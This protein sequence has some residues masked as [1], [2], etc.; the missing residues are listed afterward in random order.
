MKAIDI[1][2]DDKEEDGT[3]RSLFTNDT[4]PENIREFV[5]YKEA[6]SDV[7]ELRV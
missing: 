6:N 7:E 3:G 4:I 2:A 1:L 5:Q